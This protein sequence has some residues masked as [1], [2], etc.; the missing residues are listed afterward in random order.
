MT[1]HL[2]CRYTQK[3]PQNHLVTPMNTTRLSFL[4]RSRTAFSLIELLSVMAIIGMLSVAAVPALNTIK[5]AGGVS[6]AGYDIAGVMEQ[7]RSY[8]MAR[9][10]FV[11]VGIAEVDGTQP[12]SAV[13]TSSGVGRVMLAAVASK[14]GRKNM[15]TSNLMPVSKIYRFDNVHLD[16]QVG[17]AGNLARPAV[18]ANNKVA[19][20]SFVMDS[21]YAF[22]WPVGGSARYSFKKVI[23]F[24]PSGAVSND[25]TTGDFAKW[26]EVGLVEARG[27][28]VPAAPNAAAVLLDGVTGS[29]SVY[30]P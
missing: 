22:D 24:S 16:D 11:F 9:N 5:G 7:A 30:R 8:A 18:D 28:A 3:T 26:M 23:C 1:V 19:S 15:D 17:T 25:L 13:Q 29:V 2:P 6:K 4:P 27:N 10:T 20:G 14:N 21:A 12:E